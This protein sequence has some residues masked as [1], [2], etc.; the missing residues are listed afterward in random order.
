MIRDARLTAILFVLHFF[1]LYIGQVN[2]FNLMFLSLMTSVSALIFIYFFFQLKL[3]VET[4]TDL[5]VYRRLTISIFFRYVGQTHLRIDFY[6]ENSHWRD[7]LSSKLFRRSH[8]LKLAT[9]LADLLNVLYKT[10]SIWYICMCVRY[11]YIVESAR[12]DTWRARVHTGLC[13]VIVALIGIL[14]FHR[15]HSRAIQQQSAILFCLVF[16]GCRIECKS[17]CC[18]SCLQRPNQI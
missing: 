11:A 18:K 7:L 14:P 4:N 3:G 9:N 15:I 2:F 8:W 6:K 1:D 12:M 10:H 5:V 13:F 16:F 17:K